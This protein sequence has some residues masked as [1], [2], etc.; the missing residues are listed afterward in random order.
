MN[1][2]FYVDC[3]V[4]GAQYGQGMYCAADY[5]GELTDGIKNEMEH[6]IELGE[7]RESQKSNLQKI[8]DQQSEEAERTYR[9]TIEEGT[10]DFTD[11]EKLVFKCD[12]LYEGTQEE[13]DRAFDIMSE[14]SREERSAFLKKA[15]SVL[16]EAQSKMDDVKR[17]SVEEYADAHDLKIETDPVHRVETLTLDPS[18]NIIKYEDLKQKFRDETSREFILKRSVEEAGF[19]DDELAII[20]KD[21][22]RDTTDEQWRRAARVMSTITEEEYNSVMSRAWALS[23][24]AKS[25]SAKYQGMDLGAYAAMC[26]Y[27]AINAEGHGES[28]SY[29][30]ILNRTKTIFLDD[31]IHEDGL[32]KSTIYFQMGDDGVMYAIRDGKVIGWVNGFEAPEANASAN[33]DGGPGSGNWGHE[34][35]PG[36]LGG[37][38]PG[39]G[40]ENRVGDKQSGYTSFAKE[41]K[42]FATPHKTSKEE[43][44][45]SPNGSI[46]S[47]KKDG[48]TVRLLKTDSG[49]FVDQTT[50]EVKSSD[51]LSSIKADTAIIIPNS[52]KSKYTQKKTPGAEITRERIENTP[53]ITNPDDYDSLMRDKAG[54]VWKKADAKTKDTL[55]DYTSSEYETF[56]TYLRTGDTNGYSEGKVKESIDLMTDAIAQSRFDSDT[57]LY[58]GVTTRGAAMFLGVSEHDIERG[59]P[60]DFIGIIGQ[61]DAFLSCGSVPGKGFN[62]TVK[63]TIFCPKGTQALYAE[64]FSACG[65]GSGRSWDGKSSQA[66]YSREFETILQ[67]GTRVEVVGYSRDKYG[68][69][70]NFLVKVVGQNTEK[71]K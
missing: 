69:D 68:S 59:N 25:E 50:G 61:D 24:E 34:G 60:E 29:T 71:S 27:D 46:I 58:R 28:G 30:V 10:K 37:S 40:S 20:H 5:N 14:M 32:S 62:K 33:H 52:E 11:D 55:V 17:M 54:E 1:G 6:Y 51:Q 45:K 18:A 22:L 3:S 31:D 70:V 8:A 36:K 49:D 67:R 38:A 9:D 66:T 53:K 4:G 26:G 48:K 12:K 15:N 63:F 21:I 47:Y 64:P 39:G 43:L 13:R 23:E 19:S 44:D 42:K 2:D 16:D 56:N 35:V 7:T 41:K 65:R 57:F